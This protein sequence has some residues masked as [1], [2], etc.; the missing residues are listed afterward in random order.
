MYEKLT[1][2]GCEKLWLDNFDLCSVNLLSMVT[3]EEL[4]GG[5]HSCTGNGGGDS[6]WWTQQ[7]ACLVMVV[8]KGGAFSYRH[9]PSGVG[10]ARRGRRVI[11]QVELLQVVASLAGGPDDES[12]QYYIHYWPLEG[13]G[14]HFSHQTSG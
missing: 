13:L 9:V 12:S 6:G 3:D 10:D 11:T 7:D 4:A 5:C 8:M 2:R 1:E 14:V